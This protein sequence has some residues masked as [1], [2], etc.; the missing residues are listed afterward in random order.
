M[1][2]KEFKRIRMKLK[3]DRHEFAEVFGLSG[4]MAVANIENGSRNPS[5][6]TIII[7]RILDVLPANRAND[8]IELMRRYGKNE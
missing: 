1:K 8:F 2:A 6:L 5:K 4:Y 3:L 7:L